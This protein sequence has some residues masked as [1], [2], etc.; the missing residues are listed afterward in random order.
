MRACVFVCIWNDRRKSEDA[1]AEGAKEEE[2]MA[3]ATTI[4]AE[5]RGGGRRGRWLAPGRLLSVAYVRVCVR[6]CVR[7]GDSE[8]LA[9]G[10]V[11]CGRV[12]VVANAA[13]VAAAGAKNSEE[14]H[15]GRS[16]ARSRA[17]LV[18]HTPAVACLHHQQQQATGARLALSRSLAPSHPSARGEAERRPRAYGIPVSD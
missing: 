3:V 8:A 18:R 11:V 10:R 6:M 4:G 14:P 16:L 13:A 1:R 2:A 7:R 9:A 12:D 5:R 17:R 15:R